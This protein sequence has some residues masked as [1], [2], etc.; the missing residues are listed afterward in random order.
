MVRV[1]AFI[2]S[3]IIFMEKVMV[4]MMRVIILVKVVFFYGESDNS[5]ESGVFLW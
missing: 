5:G 3:V 2:V 4:F 1:V